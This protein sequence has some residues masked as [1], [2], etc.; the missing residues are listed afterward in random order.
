MRG[1]RSRETISDWHHRSDRGGAMARAVCPDVARARKQRV[2]F[3]DQYCSYVQINYNFGKDLV[4][5]AIR[6]VA[7][8][9]AEQSPQAMGGIRPAAVVT[10]VAL[11]AAVS[12]YSGRRRMRSTRSR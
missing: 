1:K 8:R 5:R 7:W 2:K 10:A 6:R 3:F 9:N 11:R 4:E 12:S